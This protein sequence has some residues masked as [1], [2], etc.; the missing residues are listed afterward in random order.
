M[1]VVGE[2]ADGDEA[3][4]QIDALRPDAVILDVVMPGMGGLEVL[5]RVA[6]AGRQPCVVV[7]S[8]LTE[9]SVVLDALRNGAL[10][11]VD[12]AAPQEEVVHALRYAVQGRRYLS[13]ALR[14]RAV[15][16]YARGEGADADD[17][18]A[19]L[20]DREH[21]VLRRAAAGATSAAIA[22][23][24]FLSARTVETHRAR[25]MQKLGLTSQTELVRFGIRYGLLVP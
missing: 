8:S 13:P 11:F 22:D 14:D 17:P 9:E 2:A 21:E 19:R 24:L 15:D 7:V 5:R 16:I 12:K 3:L 1:E 18:L 20:T 10:A 4:A 23:A 25:G 6:G